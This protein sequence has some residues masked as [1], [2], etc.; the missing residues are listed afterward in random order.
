MSHLC[1]QEKSVARAEGR[2]DPP[3][4][5]SEAIRALRMDDFKYAHGQVREHALF[6]PLEFRI[7]FP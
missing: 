3:L 2:P 6:I 1:M 4:Y 5:G 7:L